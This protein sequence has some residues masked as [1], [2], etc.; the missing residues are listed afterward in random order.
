MVMTL[1]RHG[2]GYAVVLDRKMMESMNIKPNSRV[3]VTPHDEFLTSE[4]VDSPEDEASFV[5]A[6]EETHREYASVFK[7]LAE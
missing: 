1:Q 4:S 7:K 6:M 3:R 2:D 5:E